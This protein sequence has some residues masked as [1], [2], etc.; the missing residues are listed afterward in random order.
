MYRYIYSPSY[1]SVRL[2]QYFINKG[3]KVKVITSNA[4]IRSLCNYMKWDMIWFE[5]DKVQQIVKRNVWNP[6]SWYRHYKILNVLVDE[7][8]LQIHE[9]EL[10]LTT[11]GIDIVGLHLIQKIADRHNIIQIRYWAE[12]QYPPPLNQSY[13]V[14]LRELITLIRFNILFSPQYTFKK[15]ISGKYLFVTDRYLVRNNIS[16]FSDDEV[17]VGDVY[18]TMKMPGVEEKS[19]SLILGGYSL[20]QDEEIFGNGLKSVY[21]V[22]QSTLPDCLYKPHPGEYKLDGILKNFDLYEYT[23]IPYEY[24]HNHLQL[25]ICLGT[26]GVAYLAKKNVKVIS[27]IDLLGIDDNKKKEWKK[28]LIESCDDSIAFPQDMTDLKSM[29]LDYSRNKDLN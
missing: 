19:I 29:L 2:I 23:D 3:D 10:Y 4:S 5:A 28:L 25:V 6:V 16:I 17:W 27:I 7:I 12:V 20:A 1:P 24:L 26:I 9:G 21:E 13:P 8:I 18:E 14:S 15:E 11:L 22:I